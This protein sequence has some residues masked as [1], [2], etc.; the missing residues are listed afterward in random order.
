MKTLEIFW[1]VGRPYTYLAIKHLEQRWEE[2][3][4]RV[5][6]RPFLIGGVFKGTGN[7]M[8]AAVPAKAAYLMR[9]LRRWAE[10]LEVPMR[11][12]GEGTP[13]PINTLNPMRA[14]VAAGME[15]KAM[16]FCLALFHAYWGEGRDVSELG[17]LTEVIGEAGLVPEALL[18]K[19]GSQEVK[20]TLRATTGEAVE[21][22][23]FGAPAIFV[24]ESH[25]WGNDRLDMAIEELVRAE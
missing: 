25:Y 5:R 1:D 3:G 13:F 14:A 12:P 18:E 7:S 16:P 2:V 9:D 11:L 10:R 24:G 4:E 20:D 23:A 19:A 8:P 6:L 15:G 17:V 22:G 21:R